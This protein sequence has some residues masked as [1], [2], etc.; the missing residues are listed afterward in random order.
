MCGRYEKGLLR[1]NLNPTELLIQDIRRALPRGQLSHLKRI[2]FCGNDGDPIV[3]RDL[4]PIL[5]YLQSEAPQARL[6]LHT[7]GGARSKEFWRRIA[8]LVTLVRF[9]VDGLANTNAVYRRNVNWDT[10]ER[11]M[12][13][14]LGA[15]G[16]A[17]VD[18]LVFAHNE[19]QTATAEEFFRSIGVGKVHFKTTSRFFRFRELTW[20]TSRPIYDSRQN[21]VG[22]LEPPRRSEW[23]S[24]LREKYEEIAERHGSV[25]NYWEQT[26]IHCRVLEEK[27]LYLS[28]EGLVFP[29]CWVAGEWP[30]RQSRDPHS[31]Q[32]EALLMKYGGSDTISIRHRSLPE[33]LNS[34]FFQKGIPQSWGLSSLR[35]GKLKVCSK[36]CGQEFKPFEAQFRQ[37]NTHDGTQSRSQTHGAP[38][39][40]HTTP[41]PAT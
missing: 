1:Q 10:L 37:G 13:A 36:T 34:D 16:L 31:Q 41:L 9:G 6:V 27:N 14:Y 30:Y 40:R 29:C 8:G 38:E 17:E 11:N 21:Q 20:Q 15:G 26:P 35:D 7:N 12:R 39:Q 19:H 33:I 22:E 5:E 3:A 28:A 4:I 23:K 24:D 32:V 2:Y 25:E 18:F